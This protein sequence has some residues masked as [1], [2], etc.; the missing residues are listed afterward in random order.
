MQNNWIL[1]VLSDLKAFACENRLD[2]LAEQLQR[3]FAVAALEMANR[4]PEEAAGHDGGESGSDYR[5]A[6]ESGHA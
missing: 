6:H 2:L 4:D 5:L 3:T 1:D